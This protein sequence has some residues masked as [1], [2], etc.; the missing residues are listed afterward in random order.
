LYVFHALLPLAPRCEPV[1]DVLALLLYFFRAG[2]CAADSSVFFFG[3]YFSDHVGRHGCYLSYCAYILI[4]PHLRGS[5]ITLLFLIKNVLCT[6][7]KT[8]KR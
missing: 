5:R 7:L 2:L 6:F 8:H 1:G 4:M 3:W